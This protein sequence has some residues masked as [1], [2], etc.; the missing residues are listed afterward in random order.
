MRNRLTTHSLAKLPVMLGFA[1][2]AAF[3]ALIDSPSA[4]SLPRKC[5]Q[6]FAACQ[7]NARDLNGYGACLDKHDACVAQNY[8]ERP[9]QPGRS[10][11]PGKGARGTGD[12]D[13][14]KK[15]KGK[16][17]G[18]TRDAAPAPPVPRRAN[19]RR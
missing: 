2:F 16:G 17:K 9:F 12:M 3:A 4:V 18:K 8:R 11:T 14:R 10:Y 5:D 15:D 6:E 1:A 13:S 7:K 19:R